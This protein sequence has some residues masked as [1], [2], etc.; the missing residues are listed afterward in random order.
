MA[1]S[2]DFRTCALRPAGIYGEGEERHLPRIARLLQSGMFLFTYGPDAIC[3][4]VALHNFIEAQLCAAE[5]LLEGGPACGNAYFISDGEPVNN[6]HFFQPFIVG[7][8]YSMPS[9]S[10]PVTVVYI[11]AYFMEILHRVL[12]PVYTFDPLITRAEVLKTGKTHY[13][14]LE[15][16]ERDLGYY[17]REPIGI[18]PS[19]VDHYRQYR[20][21]PGLSQMQTVFLLAAL[22]VVIALAVSCGW[23]ESVLDYV[24][25][26]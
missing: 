17:P 20:C 23:D 25:A 11:L 15:K 5:A 1:N 8:G 16:A 10:L 7:L 6:F 14:S 19:I 13:F 26:D 4:F 12:A 9:L 24:F 2:D 22:A 18:Q 3:E 21:R